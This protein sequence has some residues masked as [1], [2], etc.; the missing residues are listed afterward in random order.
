MLIS[1]ICSESRKHFHAL[2]AIILKFFEP[3][4][5]LPLFKKCSLISL[6]TLLTIK[7]LL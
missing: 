3:Q 6:D 7:H 1:M 2:Q 4:N 5:L